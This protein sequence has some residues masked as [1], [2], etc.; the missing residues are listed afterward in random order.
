MRAAADIG[1]P[2]APFI[3]RRAPPVKGRGRTELIVAGGQ[4][5]QVLHR[6]MMGEKP[7]WSCIAVSG[8]RLF[9]RTARTLY[10]IGRK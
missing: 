1:A 5:F 8:G 2:P 6:A 7:C 3:L 9:L 4:R 10:C